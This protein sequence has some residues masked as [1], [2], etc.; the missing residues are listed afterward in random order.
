MILSGFGRIAVH[1]RYQNYYLSG[2]TQLAMHQVGR[3]GGI[4]PTPPN[5]T[6]RACY[7]PVE[8]LGWPG[9]R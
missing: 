7:Q 1:D 2:W 6:R 3:H 4:S 5:V 8:A 9:G